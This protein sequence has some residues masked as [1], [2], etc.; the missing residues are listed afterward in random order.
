MREGERGRERGVFT[1]LKS[2]LLSDGTRTDI[3][4]LFALDNEQPQ[5]LRG[6]ADPKIYSQKKNALQ[7]TTC[8]ATLWNKDLIKLHSSKRYCHGNKREKEPGTTLYITIY[9]RDEVKIDR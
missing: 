8:A 4:K 7:S 9:N 2:C 1:Q 3:P 6:F 5:S